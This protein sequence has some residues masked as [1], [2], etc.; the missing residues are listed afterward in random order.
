MRQHG[1]W[2]G[3]KVRGSS[4]ASASGS[5]GRSARAPSGGAYTQKRHPELIAKRG[6]VTAAVRC[7]FL[8]IA[9][10][11]AAAC[12]ASPAAAS[13]PCATPPS[14]G[15]DWP[16]YGHD[17][18][19]TRTQ[20]EETGLGPNSVAGLKPAWAFA[21][22]STGDG[23]GFNSTPVVYD[24]CV[25]VGSSGGV[26]YALDAKTG[27]VVWQRKLEAP[28]P[29][30][31][32]AIVG[33]ALVYGG[34]VV[35]LVDQFSA[36]YAIALKRST[37]AVVWK[38][39]PFAPPLTSS[40]AQAGSYT[41]S[42]PVLANGFI[43]AGYSAPEGDPTATG[44]FSL[45]NARTGEVAKTTPTIP[46]AAQA[47]GYAGGG[48]WSTPAYDPVT[49]YLYWGSGNP[50]SKTKQYR[51]TDAILKI[52]ANPARATFG[53]IVASYPGNVDQYTTT[54]QELSHSPACEV[55]ANPEAPYPLDDP[56]CGQLDLDFGAAANL[57]TTAGGTKVVGDLQKSGV[58]HTANASTMAPVWT[59]L[60]G[61]SCFACNAASTAFDGSSIYGVATP[62]G[63]MFSLER[64]TG[65]RNWLTPLPDGTH[66]QST[67]S[68]AGIAWTVDSA[69]NLDGVETAT[70]RPLVHRSLST[71]AGAP[72][73]NL[74]SS[75]VAIG[76]HE[77]FVS[78]GGLSY[79]SAPGYVVAYRATG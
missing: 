39:G 59:A 79:V 69:A 46:S 52:D 13:A 41:N 50:N 63:T 12:L 48:I 62:G 58:Y 73:T 15:G 19:N 9:L 42:S 31:G 71:D 7:C 60:V 28:N 6:G 26:A 10:T 43:A 64:G 68:A 54:L 22:N 57:F 2:G 51:T 17:A 65:S 33:A 8:V 29:G 16:S 55:S 44:G 77:L 38:S 78:A 37:G 40:A 67:S 14:G 1:M 47:E 74:T 23:T 3:V 30:S 49:K 24:G 11:L 18:A 5:A 25:F 66:Y 72:V 20:G 70:G 61:P 76:E 56:V 36:P 35:F 21:T 27:H 53:Q 75:G 34:S 4:R 32:G 45:I